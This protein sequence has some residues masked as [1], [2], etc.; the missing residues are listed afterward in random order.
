[1]K[2]LAGELIPSRVTTWPDLSPSHYRAPELLFSPQ[3]YD[4]YATDVWSLGVVFAGFFTSIQL[5]RRQDELDED[6]YLPEPSIN[7]RM[8]SDTPFVAPEDISPFLLNPDLCSWRRTSLFDASRGEIALIWSI[9][10]IRGTPTTE[11]WPVSP[12]MNLRLL[13]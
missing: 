11:L 10:K 2:W 12:T 6:D 5:D 9:F 13:S 4:A 1:M 8:N 3:V 7:D